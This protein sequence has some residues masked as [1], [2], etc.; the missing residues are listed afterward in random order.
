MLQEFIALF[1]GQ[2]FDIN[3]DICQLDED[4]QRGIYSKIFK[5]LNVH[6]SMMQLLTAVQGLMRST[7]STP[8]END[9]RCIAVMKGCLE[10]LLE[11]VK[12]DI[13]LQVVC[14][15]GIETDTLLIPRY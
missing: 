11:L 2:T 12:D 7:A 3:G 8:K 5:N 10:F 14:L 1:H 9:D 15:E 4:D 6:A 13:D